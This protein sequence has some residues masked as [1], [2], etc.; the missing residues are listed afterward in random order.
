[1]NKIDVQQIGGFPLETDTLNE[2]QK[3]YNLLQAFGAL[4]APL[5]IISGCVQTGSHVA[6]GVVYINGEVLEFRGG[7]MS[8]TVI[9]REETETREFENGQEKVV[10]RTRWATFGTSAFGSYH[11]ADFHRTIGLKAIE[12]RLV[13]PGFIQDYYGNLDSI[14]KGWYLCDGRNGTPDLRGLFV[15]GYDERND[16]YNKPGSTG[17]VASVTLN[18]G[19]LP[20]HSHSGKLTIPPHSHVVDWQMYNENGSETSH[21]ASGGNTTVNES[22]FI[23][24]T[25]VGGGGTYDLSINS[26]GQG[27]PIENRPPFMVLCKIMYKG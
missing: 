23:E 3:A 9:I 26:T 10:Y 15:V 6:N 12:S 20:P 22:R 5:A 8:S 24:N 21:M 16:E 2:M 19:Q 4:S 18:E 27:K 13:F 1:M 25:D 7:T 11:W 14:P 17:G